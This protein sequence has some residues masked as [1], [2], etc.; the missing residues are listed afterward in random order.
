M[1][2]ACS[3]RV[4]FFIVCYCLFYFRATKF[5]GSGFSRWAFQ[6]S[7]TCFCHSFAFFET[8]CQKVKTK[9]D[10][11]QLA[12]DSELQ[13]N[14]ANSKFFLFSEKNNF[15]VKGEKKKNFQGDRQHIYILLTVI[16]I[17]LKIF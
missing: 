5:F 13:K 10:K 17:L 15:R 2:V 4:S 9:K 1:L 7:R 12:K 6:R 14:L 11:S 16:Y 8:R 3:E